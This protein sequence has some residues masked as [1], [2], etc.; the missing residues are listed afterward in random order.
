MLSTRALT[1]RISPIGAIALAVFL[2]AFQP[3]AAHGQTLYGSLTGNIADAT[4]AAVPNAKIE[5]LDVATGIPEQAVSD[6][7]VAYVIN[8]LQPG[9]YRVTISA[10]AFGSL[11]QEGVAVDANTIRSAD[12]QLAVSQVNQS[13]TVDASIVTLQTDRADVNTQLRTMQLTGL[14]E[15]GSRN[16]QN[17]FKLV[18]GFSPPAAAHS[19]AGNPQGALAMNV[20]GASYNNNATRLDGALDTYPWLPEIAACVPPA[21]SIQ[22]VNVVTA[23]FDAEQGMAGG[24]VINVGINPEPMSS[25]A[26]A[27]NTTPT[28]I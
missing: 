11:V 14:P 28:A 18:P 21:D 2:A 4:G 6:E 13:L 24:S 3:T 27:G 9:S 7:R 15:A 5:A 25:T 22:T 12:A 8:D 26:P 10:A 20:N 16:F 1:L 23:S 17:L 19:E